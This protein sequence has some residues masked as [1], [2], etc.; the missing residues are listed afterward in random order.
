VAK[1]SHPDGLSILLPLLCS[2]LADTPLA[3]EE[4]SPLRSLNKTEWGELLAQARRQTVSGLMYQAVNL[5]PESVAVPDEVLFELMGDADLIARRNRKIAQTERILK[6]AFAGI[7]LAPIVMK[8]SSCARLYPHPELR[9]PGDI[10]LYF[11]P[12]DFQAA[13]RL[14]TAKGW[15]PVPSPDGSYQYSIDGL[16]IDQHNRYFDLHT[17]PDLLPQVPSRKAELLMLSAHILKHASGAGIGLRQLCDMAAACRAYAGEM[18]EMADVYKTAGILEWNRLLASFLQ[19]YLGTPSVEPA[20]SPAPLLSIVRKG[21]DFGRHDA[22]RSQ[23]LKR[24]AP[25]R[26]ADTA[27]RMLLRLPFALRYAPREAIPAFM[28]M[29]KG[30]MLPKLPIIHRFQSRKAH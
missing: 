12:G 3:E 26:K 16:E 9:V 13:V 29:I 19:K 5:L 11:P 25:L 14:A 17:N 24:P 27:L 18:G 20:Y 7:G 2:A 8:G 23:A 15:G 1:P 21:A 28:D 10:D 6:D 22:S 4:L 30:N